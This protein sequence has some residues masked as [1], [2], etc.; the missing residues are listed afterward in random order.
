VAVQL[1]AQTRD[2]QPLPAGM[3]VLTDKGLAGGRTRRDFHPVA[4][5]RAGRADE[6][7]LVR[8]EGPGG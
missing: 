5:V 6:S 2:Q 3:V 8:P 1:L 7:R 4:H